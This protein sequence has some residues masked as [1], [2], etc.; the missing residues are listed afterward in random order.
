[1]PVADIYHVFW[2]RKLFIVAMT[3]AAIGAGWYL[4][5]RERPTYEAQT[6]VRVQQAI[7]D[8][9]E[10]FGALQTGGRL[11]Q[12]YAT[13]AST[14]TIAQ[15]V[16]DKLGPT[17]P[18]PAIAGAITGT[19][20]ADLELLK[21][22]AHSSNPEWAAEI[23]N[24]TPDALRSF[25]KETGT[26]RD[27]VITVERARVPTSPSSPSR[28]LNLALAFLVGLILSCALAL[29]IEFVRDGVTGPEELERLSRK[30]VLA[31]I[32]NLHLYTA[33]ELRDEGRSTMAR[34]RARVRPRG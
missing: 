2:R 33:T 28:K 4:T 3:L 8:P 9:A 19:Q 10:A 13:I 11:A 25:I 30:P 22:I 18:Y 26:L 17:V 21:I 34:L 29:L 31:T 16:S 27:Q 24:A 6:L 23:A 15:R 7:Q 14:S 5:S 20:V 12:T 32:P 1:M